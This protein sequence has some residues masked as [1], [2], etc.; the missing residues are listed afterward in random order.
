MANRS[1]STRIYERLVRHPAPR[2]KADMAPE[3]QAGI[4]GN[5][6]IL[7]ISQFL[8]QL[9]D[10]VS[11]PKIILPWIMGSVGAPLY[12]LGFLVPIRE[13]GSLLPQLLIAEWVSRYRLRKWFW[14]FGSLF[15]SL[16]IAGIGLVAWHASGAL[17]GW[18]IIALLSAFSL[19]RGLSSTASKDVLGKTIPK[20]QRGEVNGWSASFSG[21]ITLVMGA[22]LLLHNGHPLEAPSYGYL[23]LMASLLWA[24]AALV[25]IRIRELPGETRKP[26]NVMQSLLQR[27]RILITD[28]PFRRFVIT[29]S[30]LLC[31]ALTAP[32]YVALAQQLLGNPLQLL[33]MFVLASGAAS[34]VSGPVWGKFAD[35][36][37]AAVMAVGSF[38]A[39]GLGF[40]V[41]L[42]A[43]LRP[44]WL[45]LPWLLPLCYFFL[46]I[47]HQGVRIGRKTYVVDMAEGNLRTDYVAVSNTIIGAVLLLVGGLGALA[48]LINLNGIILMLS[49]AGL[50]GAV[51][52]SCLRK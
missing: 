2:Q 36:S 47:A 43:W 48:G 42:L 13:A 51:M 41:C 10:A 3:A 52:A 22:I 45:A 28:K 24:A 46:S 9:G 4:P 33:G 15:Q 18:L 25:F 20:S 31:S 27:S 50:M 26:H 40:L 19:A 6:V 11:N 8:V 1:I 14:V 32:Y 39:A 12:Q 7:L 21:L 38:I 49:T 5:F 29:R 30:L 23:I 16:A 34:L 44:D 35:V 17:A 37:S